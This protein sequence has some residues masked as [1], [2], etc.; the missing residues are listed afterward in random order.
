MSA[1]IEAKVRKNAGLIAEEMLGGPEPDADLGPED[2]EAA[3]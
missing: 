2:E 1:E 3:G